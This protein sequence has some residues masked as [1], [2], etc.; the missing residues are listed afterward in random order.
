VQGRDQAAAQVI[1]EDAKMLD[2]MGVFSIVLE[3]VPWQLA[4][5]ITERVNAPT[6]G[7]G[8]GPY[9]NGQ[10]LVLH[11][12]L[13]MSVGELTPKFVKRYAQLNELIKRA[14]VE[15]K[16]EV[17]AGKFPSLEHA[18]AMRDDELKKLLESEGGGG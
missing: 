1:L 5:I 17:K 2:E 14:L 6:I 9:C 18:Y 8:A 15:F 10:V 4:K 12:L 11:D 13:G 16:D 3:C 7:I